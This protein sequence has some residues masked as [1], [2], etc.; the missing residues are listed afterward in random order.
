MSYMEVKLFKDAKRV[1]VKKDVIDQQK[2][3]KK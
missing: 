1:R 2:L 3:N